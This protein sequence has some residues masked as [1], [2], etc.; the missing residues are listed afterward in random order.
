[1]N[2]ALTR[3]A[4]IQ[5]TFPDLVLPY[6]NFIGAILGGTFRILKFLRSENHSD[7]YAVEDLS[8]TNI[9]YEAKAYVLRGVPQRTRDYRI[10][11]LKKL[12]SKPTFIYSFD[13]L[14]RKFVINRLEG[15]G[16]EA[17]TTSPQSSNNKACKLGAIGR[18]NTPEF[19]EAFPK[20]PTIRELISMYFRH[21]PPNQSFSMDLQTTQS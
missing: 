19:D 10:R 2:P 1:M 6:E 9:R 7:V 18:R 21:H 14:G 15:K 3:S 11:N 20:L 5:A 17:P 16:E 4:K 13:Q 12:A 8:S